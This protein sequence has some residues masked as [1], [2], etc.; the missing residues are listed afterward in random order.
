MF[1]QRGLE[2]ALRPSR[3]PDG[4]Q[5]LIAA[6]GPSKFSPGLHSLSPD[7]GANDVQVGDVVFRAADCG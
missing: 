4:L 6:S 1:S 3:Q 7:G 2:A 5:T